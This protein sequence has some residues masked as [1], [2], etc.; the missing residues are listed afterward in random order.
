MKLSQSINLF[1]ICCFEIGPIIPLGHH[2]KERAIMLPKN[3]LLFQKTT[4]TA[5]VENNECKEVHRLVSGN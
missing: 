4:K 2:I 1:L 5:R 3:Y